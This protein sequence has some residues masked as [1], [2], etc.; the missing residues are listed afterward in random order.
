ME[1]TNPTKAPIEISE[2]G[3]LTWLPKL[4]RLQ[5]HARTFLPLSGD[6]RIKVAGEEEISCDKGVLNIPNV[7]STNGLSHDANQDF[8]PALEELKLLGIKHGEF[9]QTRASLK[10]EK[11]NNGVSI[12]DTRTKQILFKLNYIEDGSMTI[13]ANP[14]L[15]LEMKPTSPDDEVLASRILL[16]HFSTS[17]KRMHKLEAPL[18]SSSVSPN[19][20]SNEN[21]ILEFRGNALY[22]ESKTQEL[23]LSDG[24]HNE[25]IKLSPDTV[26]EPINQNLV[27]TAAPRLASLKKVEIPIVDLKASLA[28]LAS[29]NQQE[30]EKLNE[31]RFPEDTD[32]A[33]KPKEVKPEVAELKFQDAQT[34]VLV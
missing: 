28:A 17:Q 16:K 25:V 1:V 29:H 14:G 6:W 8:R 22:Y 5:K 13:K 19:F 31:T 32:Q 30:A 9:P 27:G 10:F 23:H 18:G 12:L 24:T 34:R 7:I 33:K 26:A 4:T 11:N 15:I 3:L 2:K 20:W 21:F